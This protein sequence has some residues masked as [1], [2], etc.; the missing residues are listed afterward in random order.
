MI[1]NFN[2]INED[3]LKFLKDI[4]NKL[5]AEEYIDEC[6]EV[7]SESII[8]GVSLRVD[9]ISLFLTNECLYVEDANSGDTLNLDFNAD[10]NVYQILSEL[11]NN[12]IAIKFRN[13]KVS[14]FGEFFKPDI[15]SKFTIIDKEV[16]EDVDMLCYL[17]EF[18]Q[19]KNIIELT[20]GNF[21]GLYDALDEWN[22]LP[23]V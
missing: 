5:N 13:V 14:C 10:Y 7:D 15:D 17:L 23:K 8:F 2:N 21:D 19:N 3:E 6:Y 20:H 22:K 9:D 12:G 1:K 16:D 18:L 11:M 4:V